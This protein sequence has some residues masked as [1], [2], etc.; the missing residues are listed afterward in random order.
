MLDYILLIVCSIEL[1]LMYWMYVHYNET[2][3]LLDYH[4]YFIELLDY[5]NIN[6]EMG[7]RVEEPSLE[8][9]AMLHTLELSLKEKAARLGLPIAFP[10]RPPDN[11]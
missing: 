6:L 8:E 4:Q 7:T 5:N 10:Q 3:R 11:N 1:F 9:E 2:L